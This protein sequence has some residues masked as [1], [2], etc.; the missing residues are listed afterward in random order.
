MGHLSA[1]SVSC[2][3]LYSGNVAGDMIKAMGAGDFEDARRYLTKKNWAV[4]AHGADARRF[5]VCSTFCGHC[6][7]GASNNIHPLNHLRVFKAMLERRSRNTSGNQFTKK[8]SWWVS[9]IRGH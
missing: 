8:K 2:K 4:D 1:H 5:N 7:L 3:P 6:A 9:T